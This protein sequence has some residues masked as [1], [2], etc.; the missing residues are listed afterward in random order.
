[1]TKP[2]S[3]LTPLALLMTAVAASTAQAGVS[4]STLFQQGSNQ[5][6]DIGRLYL[7]DRNYNNIAQGQAGSNAG[8]LN[9]GDSL[10]G[11]FDMT[12]VNS[13]S[14]NV[15]GTT[16]VSEWTGVYQVMVT[17]ESSFLNPVTNQTDYVFTFGP[18]PSFEQTYGQGAMVAMFNDPS[19]NFAADYTDP[20]PAAV[21]PHDVN[22]QGQPIDDGTTQPAPSPQDVS[23]GPYQ[24]ENAFLATASDG[25]PFWTMGFDGT[26][27]AAKAGEGWQAVWNGTN[28][29]LTAFNLLSGTSFGNFNFALDRLANSAGMQ[30]GSVPLTKI[31]EASP[32]APF[33]GPADFFG[34]GSFNGVSNLV[35]PFESSTTL[36]MVF[37]VGTSGVVPEPGSLLVWGA[38]GLALGGGSLARRRRWLSLA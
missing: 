1:M 4:V 34:T 26:N 5:A 36:N 3:W 17:G 16:G 19:N 25:T 31:T 33:S 30:G 7:V 27:G 15:G 28:N 23:V 6:H 24:Q 11:S 32:P 8:Q 13:G 21:P 29:V 9:V 22:S 20:P 35:T 38:V 2:R 10:R 12:E 37:Q 18:D 14:A